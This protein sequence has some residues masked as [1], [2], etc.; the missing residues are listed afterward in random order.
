MTLV[1]HELHNM[2]GEVA[3]NAATDLQIYFGCVVLEHIEMHPPPT[4]T[5]KGRGKRMKK[6]VE[7]TVE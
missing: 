2:G 5:T 6:G 3:N 4:S 1:E 7:R